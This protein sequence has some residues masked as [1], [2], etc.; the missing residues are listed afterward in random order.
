MERKALLLIAILLMLPMSMILTNGCTD[1]DSDEGSDKVGVIVSILPQVDMV[2]AVGGEYVDVTEMIPKG[3]SPHAYAPVTSQMKAVSKASIYF[4]VGSGVEFE[5]NH[6]DALRGQN[7]DMEIVACSDG[8][9]LKAMDEHYHT[10]EYQHNETTN[11]TENG[12]DHEDHDHDHDH[13]QE[14]NDPHIWLSILN[15]K[16]MV[17]NICEGL[18]AV[19]GDHADAYRANRDDYLAKLDTLYS[20]LEGD[21][22]SYRDHAFLTQHPSLGYFGD[23]FDLVQLAIEEEGK[24]P[25][26]AGVTAIIEQAKE[27]N[28]K[29][30][31]VSPQFD[32]SDAQT[33]ADEIGGE[34][35]SVN[36]L[37]EDYI[38]NMRNVGEQMV[39]GF[40][41]SDDAQ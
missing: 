28:I 31:F 19:D 36:P 14:G 5:E 17:E 4:T 30:V 25:G 2:E 1:E 9:A 33:I 23:D 37:P 15:A 39:K 32:D 3:E 11:A 8:I 22:A 38:A 21:L 16:I 41:A 26:P 35:I 18:I 24:Q 7:A 6:L 12:D 29:V 40:Q 10:G 13:D 34:V 20:D 27:H